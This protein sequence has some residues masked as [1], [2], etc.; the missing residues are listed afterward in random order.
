MTLTGPRRTSEGRRR[1]PGFGEL[2]ARRDL[3]SALH[4][5]ITRTLEDIRRHIPKEGFNLV[6]VDD[7]EDV[8]EQLY[9]LR[10]FGTREEAERALEWLQAREDAS[11]DPLHIYGPETVVDYPSARGMPPPPRHALFRARPTRSGRDVR[12]RRS[13]SS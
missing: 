2:A 9:L 3:R 6:G 7:F 1:L 4:D 10:H 11:G 5:R 8:G 12:G 13:D